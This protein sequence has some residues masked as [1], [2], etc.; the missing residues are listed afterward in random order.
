MPG[1]RRQNR[2]FFALSVA[3][4]LLSGCVDAPDA[5]S[6]P[7]SVQTIDLPS[8]A[9]A[10]SS[11]PNLFV[12]PRGVV[13]LSWLESTA[14]GQHALR[15]STLDPRSA[16]DPQSDEEAPGWSAARTIVE[17]DD[18]FVNWADFPSLIVLEDGSMAVHWLRRSGPDTFDYDVEVAWSADGGDTWNEP[19]TPHRDGTLSE[20]G[21]ASMFPWQG[22]L[23][24]VWLD[25]RAFAGWDE[26]AG[27][28]ID[29][30]RH[31][32]PEMALRATTI[33]PDGVAEEAVL[34]ARVCEC[35]QTSAVI[36]SEGP[37][38]VYRDRSQDETRDIGVVRYREGQ[39][40]EP[41]LIH[42][43]GWQIRGC[44]VNG[45]M[46]TASGSNVAVAWFTAADGER[47]VKVAFS[48]DAG[49][50][51]AAPQRVDAG[52]PAGRVAL[53]LLDDQ[54][55]AVIWLEEREGGAAIRLRRVTR[56]G[57]QGPAGVLVETSLA[58]ASGFPRMVRSGDQLLLAWTDADTP[59]RVHTAILRP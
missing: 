16:A 55:A 53:T 25:G 43:D 32:D 39:W 15:F 44:P 58:R 49:A 24:I 54:E 59:S 47:R 46:A 56:D 5:S 29:S 37:L 41:M 12:D 19:V 35:C 11:A 13:V 42:A 21:F 51:F 38:I 10:G 9:G 50:T 27:A 20:H 31:D 4:M 17:A 14:N 23:G 34:D 40:T 22:G 52:Q 18:L 6:N 1:T 57:G 48:A 7:Q 33:S 3:C 28:V 36:T 45:P 26:T 30:T 8:P 2:L